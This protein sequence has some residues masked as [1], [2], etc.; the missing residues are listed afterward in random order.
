MLADINIL[1]ERQRKRDMS[2]NRHLGHLTTSYHKGQKQDQRTEENGLLLT[3]EEFSKRCSERGY[4][5]FV[6]GKLFEH[7]VTTYND[8][9]YDKFIE[10]IIN[11]IEN[12]N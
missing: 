11:Y 3:Y 12:F 7:D 1:F 10:K 9:E 5:K 8:T 6:I 4:D 2:L